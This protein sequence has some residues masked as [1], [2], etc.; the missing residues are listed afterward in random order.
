MIDRD[1]LGSL[2]QDKDFCLEQ[3]RYLA[4]LPD[5]PLKEGILEY[6]STS[7]PVFCAISPFVSVS[8]S[9]LCMGNKLEKKE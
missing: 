8:V 4:K 1:H 7:S 5:S 3:E 9:P 2:E 6:S